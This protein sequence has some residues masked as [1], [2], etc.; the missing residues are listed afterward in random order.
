MFIFKYELSNSSLD[1]GRFDLIL[2]NQQFDT[3]IFIVKCS[4]ESNVY[5]IYF[6]ESLHDIA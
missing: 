2:V 1:G 4:N 3:E 6:R 5:L